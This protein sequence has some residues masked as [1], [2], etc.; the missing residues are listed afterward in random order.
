MVDVVDVV[1]VGCCY[2]GQDLSVHLTID[3]NCF[4][5]YWKPL[6]M[7]LHADMVA[8]GFAFRFGATINVKGMVVWCLKDDKTRWW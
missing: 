8:R 2:G 7:T 5:I 4:V 6:L 3:E 1:V